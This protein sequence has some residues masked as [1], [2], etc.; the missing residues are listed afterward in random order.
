MSQ[1][2]NAPFPRVALLCSADKPKSL[3]NMPR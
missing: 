1:V 2:R 3:R